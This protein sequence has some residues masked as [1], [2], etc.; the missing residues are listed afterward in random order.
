MRILVYPHSMELGGSQ[1]N[2]L[3]LAR[4][5]AR[6]GHDVTLIAEPG[7]L[8]ELAIG[9]G[10]PVVDIPFARRRPS[11]A[12]AQTIWR[13]VAD[14][15]IEVVHA[16][17]WPPI[18]EAWWSVG[19]AGRAQ[20]VGTIMSMSVAP[21]LPRDIPLTLGTADIVQS[22]VDLGFSRTMLLEPPVD[23]VANSPDAVLGSSDPALPDESPDSADVV[24]V[25]RLVPDLKAS[26]IREAIEAIRLVPGAR[27]LVV[28]D[29]PLRGAFERQAVSVNRDV[30][31]QAVLICGPLS[32][33]RPAYAQADVVL[34]MGGSALRGMAFGKPL[35]VAGER[36]F[37]RLADE[38]SAP[39]FS[40]TGWFGIGDGHSGVGAL[41]AL[42]NQ[43]IGD[44]PGRAA[45]GSF[46]RDWILRHYDLQKAASELIRWCEDPGTRL[47]SSLVAR[48]RSSG[49]ALVGLASY[50]I[51]RLRQRWAGTAARDDFNAVVRAPAAA[52]RA[53]GGR[54]VQSE[55]RARPPA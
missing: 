12:V 28:G 40:R 16:F 36:G 33:P 46:G 35:V 54:P 30:G 9:W 43:L 47:P 32:D 29:G 4:E 17:E 34:G 52:H 27:L 48:S 20:V 1:L 38:S 5:Y 41:A 37:W 25:T 31:R 24:M 21:F 50:K 6:Q 53:R 39:G 18:L 45:L 26:G 14:R 55:G 23:A 44:A 15:D 7:R 3:D 22:A 10:L 42:L 2:A 19:L 8:R 13:T 51:D 11:V 49:P